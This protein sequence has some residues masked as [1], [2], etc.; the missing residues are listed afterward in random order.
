MR[1]KKNQD[2][3]KPTGQEN[4]MRENDFIVSKTDTKGKITYGNQEFI[5]M[6]GY[7]EEEL[8]GAPHNIIRHPDMPKVVFKLLWKTIADKKEIF[9][10]VLNL[11]KDGSHYWVFANVTPD[12]DKDGK[13]VG[14]LSVRRK[15]SE[16]AL[17][18]IKL[19]YKQLLDEERIGTVVDSEKLLKKVLSEKGMTYEGF[20]LAIT[21]EEDIESIRQKSAKEGARKRERSTLPRIF[22]K[23]SSLIFL[24]LLLITTVLT[25]SIF[26]ESMSFW[27]ALFPII[28]IG[29]SVL[30]YWKQI[31]Y[32]RLMGEV[33]EV[34]ERMRRSDFSG[35]IT[36]IPMGIFG[37]TAWNIND[38]LDQLET[39]MREFKTSITATKSGRE[40]RPPL[41]Q[42]LSGELI[43]LTE[44]VASA[45]L[46]LIE[47]GQQKGQIIFFAGIN[48]SGLGYLTENL[49]LLRTDISHIADI[50]EEVRRLADMTEKQA[51][52]GERE[53]ESIF[54]A[55]ESSTGLTNQIQTSMSELNEKEAQVLAVVDFIGDVAKQTNMLALNAAIEAA[56]AGEHGRGFAVVA[57]EV[58]SL[59]GKVEKAAKEIAG[60]IAVYTSITQE[61]SRQVGI[62]HESANSSRELIPKVRQAHGQFL[63]SAHTTSIQTRYASHKAFIASVKLG[64]VLYK[65][66]AYKVIHDGVDSD[67]GRA[68]LVDHTGC[69][70]GKWMSGPGKEAFGDLTIFERLT[71]PHSQVHS[72]VHAAMKIM[73]Q[74][75]WS[76][77]TVNQDRVRSDFVQMEQ[78]STILFP[79]LDQTVDAR[80]KVATKELSK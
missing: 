15:P 69:V 59:A 19:L 61:L 68:L 62:V 48:N 56:R 63:R 77:S 58:R 75:D 53:L 70:L 73:S 1:K 7:M 4:A 74:K 76:G 55:V 33:L 50:N 57:D 16:E 21:P 44:C 31:P 35:R 52:E 17:K 32:V 66:N 26:G 41:A 23:V 30:A 8:L 47:N 36:R 67:T 80:Y 6:S 22:G 79:L 45:N 37:D 9:A 65:A 46:T 51:S 25:G 60:T 20:V 13:H 40:N 24:N 49:Q 54:D 3:A 18:E 38:T 34:T 43:D 2:K 29:Y 5:K 39:M 11:A 42:G 78:G 27:I 71:E 14:Y 72:S 28:G 12:Y 64:H 10:Y